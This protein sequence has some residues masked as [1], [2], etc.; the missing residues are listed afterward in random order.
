MQMA[1]RVGGRRLAL[2]SGEIDGSGAAELGWTGYV[3]AF[4]PLPR[5]DRSLGLSLCD[6]TR[7]GDG[8]KGWRAP[9]S[10]RGRPPLAQARRRGHGV[11]FLARFGRFVMTATISARSAEGG[12]RP[13][14]GGLLAIACGRRG[15][16]ARPTAHPAPSFDYEGVSGA[17]RRGRALTERVFPGAG[18]AGLALWSEGGAEREEARRDQALNGSR[19]RRRRPPER[20][21]WRMSVWRASLGRRRRT[22]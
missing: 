22:T 16:P 18:R 12:R 21:A 9:R 3:E 2:P 20:I 17:G 8:T 7:P 5:E 11:E 10:G 19:A 6:R 13:P 14:S 1:R 4:E 15:G